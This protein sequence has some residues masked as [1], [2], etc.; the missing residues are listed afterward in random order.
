MSICKR[1]RPLIIEKLFGEISPE[2]ENRINKHLQK[3][4]RCTREFTKMQQ[5]LGL[6][7]QKEN[8]QPEADFWDSYYER[9][10]AR[11]E[12]DKEHAIMSK[13]AGGIE[14]MRFGR[15]WNPAV[16]LAGLAATLVL[17]IIIGRYIFV[18]VPSNT[19]QKEGTLIAGRTPTEIRNID[20]RTVQLFEKSKILLLGLVNTEP[21][22]MPRGEMNFSI[23]RQ[24]SQALIRE[25]SYL[26][27]NLVTSKQRR[28]EKLIEELEIILLEIANMEEEEDIPGLEMI[29]SSIEG[30]GMLMKLNIQEMNTSLSTEDN[31]SAP[32]KL[33]RNSTL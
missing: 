27:D 19:T 23:H 25:T 5:T 32:V 11:M 33:D 2:D 31:P 21:S 20:N 17:G 8:P 4:N 18:T 7:T 6:M 10:R 22:E 12:R 24:A 15:A 30:Q 9:L 28:L 3:C 26:K 14:K 29:K 1:Y 16:K 13:P